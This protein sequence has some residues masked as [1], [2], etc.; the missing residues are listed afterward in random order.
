MAAVT[1]GNVGNMSKQ[2]EEAAKRRKEMN[3]AAKLLEKY[4]S[5][6]PPVSESKTG[7]NVELPADQQ[8]LLNKMGMALATGNE[9]LFNK[10]KEQYEKLV[11]PETFKGGARRRRRT[12]HRRRSRRSTR[13]RHSRR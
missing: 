13:R 7:P 10:L 6:A 5:T 11:R 3:E 2:L 9:A 12:Q 1:R 4:G 8:A